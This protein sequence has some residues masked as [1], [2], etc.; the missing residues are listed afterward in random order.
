MC[1]LVVLTDAFSLTLRSIF[2]WDLEYA[3][4][5]DALGA[6]SYAVLQSL[7]YVPSVSSKNAN[8]FADALKGS[9]TRHVRMFNE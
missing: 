9:N 1:A 4:A 5:K 8:R 7:E 2:N 6:A 3:D